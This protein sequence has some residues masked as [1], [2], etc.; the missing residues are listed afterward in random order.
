[1]KKRSNEAP[2]VRYEVDGTLFA[3]LEA[4]IEAA[5]R[6]ILSE[7][8]TKLG[9][10]GELVE[11]EETV[12]KTFSASHPPGAIVLV[13]TTRATDQGDHAFELSGIK[14]TIRRVFPESPAYRKY[15]PNRWSPDELCIWQQFDKDASFDHYEACT[16]E[17]VHYGCMADFIWSN[18]GENVAMAIFV[19]DLRNRWVKSETE[20]QRNEAA[21]YLVCEMDLGLFSSHHEL[22][23]LPAALVTRAEAMK[24]LRDNFGNETPDP[25]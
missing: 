12:F 16:P 13:G 1:M 6:A 3:E 2:A 21:E 20:Q 4:A 25:S 24:N 14:R 10:S 9:L 8:E 17:E 22:L 11:N 5:K 19:E 15:L 18:L 23:T 7:A